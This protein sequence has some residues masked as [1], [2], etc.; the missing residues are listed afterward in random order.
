MPARSAWGSRS[1]ARNVPTSTSCRRAIGSAPGG[2]GIARTRSGASG[3]PRPARAARA[4]SAGQNVSLNAWWRSSGPEP[5]PEREPPQPEVQAQP[6]R[7]AREAA[8]ERAPSAAA[9]RAPGA[10]AGRPRRSGSRRTARRAPSPVS[11]ALTV[12]AANAREQPVRQRG[13]VARRLVVGWPRRPRARSAASGPEPQLVVVGAVALG[14]LACGG[15]L[16]ERG[17]VEPDAEGLQPAPR[18]GQR[19]DQA[20]VDPARQQHADGRVGLQVRAH[21]GR[22]AAPAPRRP[23]S[24]SDSRRARSAGGR[25]GRA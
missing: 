12:R 21:G 5:G 25:P 1:S 10:R 15:Q 13:R 23:A 17:D 20:G 7:G 14:H 16:V 11:T 24:A 8:H 19:G 2:L 22:A 18:G 6:P 3:S 9:A 4:R